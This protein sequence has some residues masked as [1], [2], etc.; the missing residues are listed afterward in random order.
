M[1]IDGQ[2]GELTFTIITDSIQLLT[3][4]NVQKGMLKCRQFYNLVISEGAVSFRMI[5]YEFNYNSI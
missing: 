4:K 5:P 2:I 3:M 1:I